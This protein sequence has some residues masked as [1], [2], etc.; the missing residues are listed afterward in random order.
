MPLIA[1]ESLHHGLPRFCKE[2][3]GEKC[4]NNMI[5]QTTQTSARGHRA[6]HRIDQTTLAGPV[7]AGAGTAS[8][9]LYNAPVNICPELAARRGVTLPG[10]V[11]YVARPAW[12]VKATTG[13]IGGSAT[14]SGRTA[15][16]PRPR[17]SWTRRLGPIN[18]PAPEW[19]ADSDIGHDRVGTGSKAIRGYVPEEPAAQCEGTCACNCNKSPLCRCKA[20]LD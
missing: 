7:V 13:R 6:R 11:R 3:D 19:D 10:I 20:S 16:L 18:S 15:G 9:Q 12:P 1:G 5:R 17:I 14:H 2:N 4:S 8:P